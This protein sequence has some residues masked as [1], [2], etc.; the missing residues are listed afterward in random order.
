[1]DIAQKYSHVDVLNALR[2]EYERKGMVFKTFF[3]YIKR[4]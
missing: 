4:F 1:M 3:I 2:A